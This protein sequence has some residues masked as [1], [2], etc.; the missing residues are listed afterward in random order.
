NPCGANNP[1]G[2]S[3]NPCGGMNPC[4]AN[5]N[6]CGAAMNPCGGSNPCSGSEN[7]PIR[8]HAFNSTD[9]AI[10]LGKKLWA[11]ESLGTS[12]VACLSCH[13][14]YELLNLDKKEGFPHYVKM[15]GDVVTL[16][17][18]INYCMI[19]PMKGKAFKKNSKEQTAMAAYYQAYRAEYLR[20]H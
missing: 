20:T 7:T 2:A 9:E 15:V 1:C 14:D 18:M 3:M 16:D 10:S 19:N 11:D 6:P 12:E 13:A 8:S 5:N 17:Q 4:G